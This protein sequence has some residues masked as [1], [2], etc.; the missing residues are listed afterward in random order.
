MGNV[1][2][3]GKSSPFPLLS[4]LIGNHKNALF[5]YFGGFGLTGLN[6]K[7]DGSMNEKGLGTLYWRW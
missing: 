2:L 6:C 7:N 5:F 3:A 1:G 4:C